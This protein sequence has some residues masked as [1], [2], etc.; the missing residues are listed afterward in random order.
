MRDKKTTTWLLK[1]GE[2]VP[3]GHL[4]YEVR[5]SNI[6]DDCLDVMKEK[7]S[8]YGTQGNLF[9]KAEASLHSDCKR[10]LV[11]KRKETPALGRCPPSVPTMG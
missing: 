1:S 9:L 8:P 10:N 2:C 4:W 11:C 3:G 5:N 6:I 7:G